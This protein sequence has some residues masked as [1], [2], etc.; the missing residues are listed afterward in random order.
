MTEITIRT[1]R[2][3]DIEVIA[4]NNVAMANETENKRLDYATVRL[5]VQNLLADHQ[6][7][8]YLLAEQDRTVLGQLMVTYEW[9]DWRNGNFWWI[10]SVYVKPESRGKNVFRKLYERLKEMARSSGD[11]C[12]LRLYTEAN[13]HT[14]QKVYTRLGMQAARYHMYEEDWSKSIHR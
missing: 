13:N 2:P 10:Q 6:R 12:G 3:S 9:S 7:G 8:F 1:A 11:V 4:Y 14:A 5:G